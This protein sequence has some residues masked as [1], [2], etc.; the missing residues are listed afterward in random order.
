M[1][2]LE[3]AQRKADLSR[4][5]GASPGDVLSIPLLHAQVQAYQ[6]KERAAMSIEE[7][8]LPGTVQI[9]IA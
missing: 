5:L 2:G 1:E 7:Q 6:S 4:R 8:P 9:S 3:A